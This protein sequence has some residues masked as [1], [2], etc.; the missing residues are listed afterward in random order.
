MKSKLVREVGTAVLVAAMLAGCGSGN[1]TGN[2]E[3]PAE[4]TETQVETQED[5]QQEAQEG[6]TEIGNPWVEAT[7]AEANEACMRLFKLP[8]GAADV[9]W[10]INSTGVGESG[11]PGPLVEAQFTLPEYNDLEFCARAK[12]CSDDTEDI[13]GLYYDWSV[14]DDV[15]L[16]NWGM[17][18]MQGK[19]YG[20]RDDDISVQLITWFDVEIGISY[21]LST[22]AP[23]LDG[24]DIQAI[25][26][27]MYDEENEPYGAGPSDFLQY[28]S[29][30]TEFKDYDEIISYL[31]PGQGYALVDVSGG[32]DKV[33]LITELVFEADHSAYEASVYAMDNGVPMQMTTITGN[34]SSYPLRIDSEGLIYCGDNHHY[35]T[36]FM[37]DNN[38]FIVQAY[39]DDGVN[40]GSGEFVGFTRPERSFDPTEDYTGGQEGFDKLI[41]DRDSQPVIE[42]TMIE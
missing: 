13:S 37:T 17:G 5:T 31:Q 7:E 10:R 14:E 23:D 2:D 42:F 22:S 33:L 28:Q 8:D 39:I 18:N 32:K 35:E 20:Y 9:S 11:F 24:F 27:S 15:T 6:T 36:Y 21:S 1:T 29:G 16:A 4:V 3:A 30:V 12:M 26:E 40:D 19:A 41:A 25:A 34:G 38:E